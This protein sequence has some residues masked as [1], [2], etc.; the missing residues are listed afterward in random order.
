MLAVPTGCKVAARL[1][2]WQSV[3]LCRHARSTARGTDRPCAEAGPGMEL[4][5]ITCA[6]DSLGSRQRV[7][8]AI[9]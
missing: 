4:C 8:G 1:R 7:V 6:F 3:A 5:T 2:S 9:Q